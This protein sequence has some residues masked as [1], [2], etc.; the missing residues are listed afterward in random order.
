MRPRAA[1]D[2]R[3]SWGPSDTG[4]HF[5]IA[6]NRA[7]ATKVLITEVIRT[8]EATEPRYDPRGMLNA[9]MRTYCRLL[10]TSARPGPG[11][12]GRFRRLLGDPLGTG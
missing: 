1:G 10:A 4:P 7:A 11:A 5:F 12:G 8:T 6:A 2:T 3:T 9:A